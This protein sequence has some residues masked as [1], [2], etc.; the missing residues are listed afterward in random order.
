[1]TSTTIEPRSASGRLAYATFAVLL[2][3]AIVAEAITRSSY[4]QI[5]VFGIGPDLALLYG[6]GRG[7]AHGQIH[8]RAVGAYN[9]VHR[10]WGPLALGVAAALAIIPIGFLVGALAWTFHVALDRAL[11]YGM[12][13]RDGFQRP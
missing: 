4:W 11:G 13:T 3:A 12:R 5:A 1:M 6:G 10:F 8:P 2:L 9:L 7:L